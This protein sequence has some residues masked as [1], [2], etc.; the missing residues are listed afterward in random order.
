MPALPVARAG[1]RRKP[2]AREHLGASPIEAIAP[3]FPGHHRNIQALFRLAEGL[4]AR[5]AP[6]G[7]AD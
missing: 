7:R 3:Q 1:G 5:R 4:A 6:N 2:A